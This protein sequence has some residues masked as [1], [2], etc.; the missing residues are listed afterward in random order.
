[1][2]E[3][4]PVTILERGANHKI[5]QHVSWQLDEKGQATAKTNTYT[6]LATGL[7]YQGEKGEWSETRELIEPLPKGAGAVARNGQHKV[8]FPQD[9]YEGQIELQTSDGQWLRSR[10]LG[11]SYFDSESGKSV[12]ISEVTNSVGELFGG[13]VLVYPNAFTD[14]R[15]SLRLTYTKSGFEQD[16]VLEEQPPTPETF[17]LNPKTTRLQ[18][19]TEF[20][21]APQPIKLE[22][23]YAD[24][25]GG[26]I[27]DEQ[28]DFGSLRMIQGKAF[29]IDAGESSKTFP[30]SK[31]WLKIDGRDFLIEEV[32]LQSVTKELDALP[33]ARSA[34]LQSVTN[35]VRQANFGKPVIPSLRLSSK[36]TTGIEMRLAQANPI[37]KGFVLDYVTVNTGQNN[38]TFKGDTTYY[39]SAPLLL[40][41]TTTFE[42]GAVIKYAINA[43]L[44]LYVT[45]GNPVATVNWQ[46]SAYR[47]VIFTAK[48]DNSVGE[49]IVGSNG[50][51]TPNAY[52]NPALD[53]S[54]ANGLPA[55]KYARFSFAQQALTLG[56]ASTLNL[57][58][59]QFVKCNY[60]LGAANYQS[61]TANLRNILFGA[62][63]KPFNLQNLNYGAT[64]SAQHVTFD[65]STTLV[66]EGAVT[67]YSL[68]M[69]N[70]IF[71]N[72]N[73]M[74]WT[75]TPGD[76]LTGHH[77]AFYLS[78]FNF[79]AAEVTVSGTPFQSPVGAG[80]YYLNDSS[81]LRDQGS[82]SIDSTL[83]LE[84]TQKTT[85]PPPPANILLN[86]TINSATP[87][88]F[89]PVV[90]RDA[91]TP[92][93]GYHYEPLDYMCSQITIGGSSAALVLG[94]GVAVGLYGTSGFLP[95]GGGITSVG[96]PSAMN[97]LVW[98]PSV[99]EQPVRLNNI[100][101]VGSSV[102]SPSA[103]GTPKI[104]ALSFTDLP[105]QGSRQS[106]FG[107]IYAY[108]YP[109]I[110]LSGCWFRGVNL[111]VGAPSY[112]PA[113]NPAANVTLLNN[114]FERSTLSLFNGYVN[115]YGTFSQMP[116]GVT[117]Y[118]NTFW[119]NTVTLFF[120]DA[121]AATHKNWVIKD[122]LYDGVVNTFSGDGGYASLIANTHDA[123]RNTANPLGG[124][125]HVTL[126]SLTYA[127]G[128][129]GNWYINQASSS[130]TPNTALVNAG[131]RNSTA[132][133]LDGHTERTDQTPD[134]G[135]VDIGFHYKISSPPTADIVSANTCRN[136][137]V[138][139]DLVGNSPQ[140]VPLNFI[141][142]SGQTPGT[143]VQNRNH[144][145]YTPAAGFEGTHTITYKVNDGWWDSGNATVTIEVGSAPT[146]DSQTMQTCKG[147][148][149]MIILTGA[150]G[151][152]E[153]ATLAFSIVTQP[154][155]G[156]LGAITPLAG[157]HSASVVYTPNSLPM[158]FCG[159]DSF[160][161]KVNDGVR[162]SSPA[163]VTVNVGDSA[164]E[165]KCQDVMTGL[166]VPITF[167]L[168]GVDDCNDTLTFTKDSDP[169]NGTIT[170][171]N[172]TTGSVTY[173]PNTGFEGT[174]TFTF[175]V[176]NCSFS[177]P[178]QTVTINVVPA[179]TLTTECRPNRIILTWTLPSFL[180]TLAGGGYIQDFQIF[181]CSTI[182]GNCSP[183][184]TPIT[185]ISDPQITK[186][187]LRWTFEDTSVTAGQTFCYSIKFRHKN[188]CDS[189]TVIESPISN[190]GCMQICP[191]PPLGPVD[192][193]FIF[194]NTGSMGNAPLTELKNNIQTV[195]DHIES[196]SGND[197]RLALVTTET[198]QVFVRL[199]FSNNNRT[200]FT[201]ELNNI[202]GGGGVL[203][204]ESTDECL[205]TVV[206][207]LSGS[208]TRSD[209]R[210]CNRPPPLQI[211]NFSPGF[212]SPNSRVNAKKMVVLI[213]DAQPGGFC[214]VGDNGAQAAIYSIQARSK[215]IRVNA[216]QVKS[217]PLT[218][219][220]MVNYMQATC[221]WHKQVPSSGFGISDAVD[222]MFFVPGSCNCP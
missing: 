116:L 92:D 17:G 100:S 150:D 66:N 125:N 159:A 88:T 95:Q 122:N 192:V 15:A 126:T 28:L 59:A 218:T 210:N 104:V 38:Y 169:A 121:Y 195:L 4:T 177:S 68:D 203:E 155:G 176:N 79:G 98:Y 23:S 129:Y 52:A 211:N 10:V 32:E 130:S 55:I 107:Q 62:V 207:A 120:M 67:A 168:T 139:F 64:L 143:L 73:G 112:G 36:A 114:V 144:C 29:T 175:H 178:S 180:Q 174:D 12:L 170:Q 30:V 20:F 188:E 186:D 54:A 163:S 149:K 219:T 3:Q 45:T 13:N 81:G 184:T 166:N 61:V 108:H 25:F 199:A 131:S 214:D 190:L 16:V 78:P 109:I 41:G 111:T 7:N 40:T 215:C 85:F 124:P 132:A 89:N 147:V 57:S 119:S 137:S 146:A 128:P 9:I 151:C 86:T 94:N 63:V 117:L 212:D 71:A 217:D 39:I 197:Y 136:Q 204:P 213:T 33:K 118:N 216:V 5:V 181:R 24:S 156:T 96:L 221:G 208:P 56:S 154:T 172:P 173:Q 209:P 49:N 141:I 50:N 198:E 26:K 206:N 160:T 133:V 47:P 43:G 2:R 44:T 115:Y 70:C 93:L 165:A 53:L 19:L 187:P 123:F 14:V 161:F 205:N 8:F 75:G 83:L 134:S 90:Q 140:G 60:G 222:R 21:N 103:A 51:P 189:I 91:D 72:V 162:D 194:D 6:E 158:P 102:F 153:P 106:M 202:G 76:H 183:S 18:V 138:P 135:T 179:P 167:T 191:V 105:M 82:A 164:P 99:Q 80:N 1:M 148:P 152:D 113:A 65:T 220:V 157:G 185:T 48:D 200:S 34:A 110:T 84:L 11:L 171:F 201:T 77:N 42:S 127:T 46:G 87:T 196:S 182:S 37:N 22:Q 97:R 74:G 69:V 58:H 27:I 142:V 101:T 193:A 31:Q 35:T 145:T